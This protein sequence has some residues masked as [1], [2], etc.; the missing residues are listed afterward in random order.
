MIAIGID[1]GTRRLGWGVVRRDGQRLL[2][3]GHG[4]LRLDCSEELAP[5][6]V[7]LAEGLEK[8]IHDYEP[9][10]GSVEGIFF[11]KNAQSAAKLGHARGVVLMLLQRAGIPVREHAPA[12]IKR[13]LTGHGQ[14]D[15]TQVAQIVCALLGLEK[16]PPLDASDALAIAITELKRDP[17]AIVAEQV[18]K[19]N[20]RKKVA[21][22]FAAALARTKA[23]RN[24]SS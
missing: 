1:P 9:E 4:V 2:H 22:H 6:L 23:R 15:K 7:L 5:R 8:I 24:Q 3:L 17:R 20:R 18:S 11:D 10:V 16:A 12:R 21:P 14:A 19:K 13:S